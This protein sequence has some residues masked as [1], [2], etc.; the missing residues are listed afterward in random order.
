MDLFNQQKNACYPFIRLFYCFFMWPVIIFLMYTGT[1]TA[2]ITK[3]LQ[4]QTGQWTELT[5]HTRTDITQALDTCDICSGI[6]CILAI[7]KPET[8][9][10]YFCLS[11]QICKVSYFI[12]TVH[13]TQATVLP[14]YILI[15]FFLNK[16]TS[17]HLWK[18][19]LREFYVTLNF[20]QRSI[21]SNLFHLVFGYPNWHL[22]SKVVL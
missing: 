16:F 8:L 19:H 9:R 15:T 12:F 18:P 2:V 4:K 7:W 1:N 6:Q 10:K 17:V 22:I 14:H 21:S 20:Y 5:G 11:K 3:L 13:S